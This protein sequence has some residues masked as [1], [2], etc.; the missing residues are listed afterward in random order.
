MNYEKTQWILHCDKELNTVNTHHSTQT[1]YP[2]TALDFRKASV[3]EAGPG[4]VRLKRKSYYVGTHLC[5]HPKS[6][7]LL[8]KEDQKKKRAWKIK[9]K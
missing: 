9:K 6:K 1:T 3:A 7:R 5:L 2:S 8:I 4:E